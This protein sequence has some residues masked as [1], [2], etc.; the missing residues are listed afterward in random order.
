MPNWNYSQRSQF[1]EYLNHFFGGDFKIYPVTDLKLQKRGFDILVET[2]TGI[3]SGTVY[4]VEEKSRSKFY[5]DVII[6][7]DSGKSTGWV[8]SL[9]SN[10]LFYFWQDTKQLVVMRPFD[11]KQIFGLYGEQWKDKYGVKSCPNNWASESYKTL[12]VPVP[13]SELSKY[14]WLWGYSPNNPQG[15]LL[16]SQTYFD[17]Y[18]SEGNE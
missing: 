10:Y 1:T 17:T 7:F 3:Q 6:E 8:N 4:G 5:S 11:I 15:K 18:F 13:L 14:I 2:Q 12:F 9:K 16:T